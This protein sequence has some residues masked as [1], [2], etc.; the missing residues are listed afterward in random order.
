MAYPAPQAA[1]LAHAHEGFRE[2]VDRR[3]EIAAKQVGD[4]RGVD[5]IGLFLGAA[6][7]L[8]SRRIAHLQIGGKRLQMMV[9]P[10]AYKRCLHGAGPGLRQSFSPRGECLTIG[11]QLSLADERSVGL[12]DA[13]RDGEFVNVHSDVIHRCGILPSGIRPVPAC[14][15]S[16]SDSYSTEGPPLRTYAF[17]QSASTCWRI[18][19]FWWADKW[20]VFSA[21]SH[22]RE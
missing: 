18:W 21:E 12:L 2:H 17:K 10:V 22:G 5:A 8:H 6:D 14:S 7:R 11:L 13:E 9:D 4:H 20:L 1:R 19:V 3:Q 16:G 15:S